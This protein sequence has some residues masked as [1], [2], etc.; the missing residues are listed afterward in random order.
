M[1][2]KIGDKVRVR[3]DLEIG[4]WY[5]MNNRTF[6]DFVNSKMI[7]FKGK[8]VT[9]LADNCFGMY[10]I[11]EDNGEWHW[12]DE[13]FSGLA[14]S[15]PKV[16]INTDGKTTTAK[17]YEG[18]KLL[19]TAASTCSPEDTFD[20]NA[21]AKIAFDRLIKNSQ[22]NI[23]VICINDVPRSDFTKGKIYTVK[24]GF[25]YGNSGRFGADIFDEEPFESIEQINDRMKPQFVEVLSQGGE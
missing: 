14:T 23:K 9:I 13:M 22:L 8:E 1:K 4:K 21:C 12:T 20:F 24:N 2:Y 6:S 17:M 7:T 15:L 18:K 19:K 25:I 10:L 5:S 11:K 16:V 3:D